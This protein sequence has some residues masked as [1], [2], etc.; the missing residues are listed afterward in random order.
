MAAQT[1]GN[2][3]ASSD[4]S[5]MQGTVTN[6]SA[7]AGA[8]GEIVS[9]FLSTAN[10][11]S[12]TSGTPST[13]INISLTAGDWDV[14]GIMT[15][16]FNGATQ[17]GD[18]QAGISTTNNTLPATDGMIG[19]NNTRLTTTSCNVSVS[20]PP[21]RFSLAATTIVYFVAKANFS[22]GTCK[23]CGYLQAR[24]VR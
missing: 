8:I 11:L 9:A 21:Q 23:A 15:F 6:D 20:I 19:F 17:S 18:S 5:Q 3:P 24:R 14:G 10:G 7:S 1:L 2:T 22:A 13:V 4:F 12:V 16:L